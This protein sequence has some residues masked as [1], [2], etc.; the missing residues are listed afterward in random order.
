MLSSQTGQISL[1]EWERFTDIMHD[2]MTQA[3]SHLVKSQ[4]QRS[5]V[6]SAIAPTLPAMMRPAK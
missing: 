1:E 4:T 6:N 2:C 3:A 5:A